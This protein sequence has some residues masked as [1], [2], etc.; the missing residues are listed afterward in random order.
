MFIADALTLY[1]IA[2]GDAIREHG[3]Q[4]ALNGTLIREHASNRTFE[5][6]KNMRDFS[7]TDTTS[8]LSC[9]TERYGDHGHQLGAHAFVRGG[10]CSAE[11]QYAACD[12]GDNASHAEWPQNGK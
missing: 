1:A 3:A 2:V 10:T 7:S 9:R 8:K 11:Q 4:A 5:G 12:D 6:D